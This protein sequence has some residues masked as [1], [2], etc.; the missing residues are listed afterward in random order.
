M[1][2]SSQRAFVI[3]SLLMAFVMGASVILPL[4]R[5]TA[6]H[7]PQTAEEPTP[8]P[9]ATPIPIPEDPTTIQF[10]STLLHPSGLFTIQQPEGWQPSNLSNN[11]AEVKLSMTNTELQTVI[12]AFV[13]ILP[14][15]P[16]DVEA[17]SDFLNPGRL[18]VTWRNYTTW[19]E[20]TRR[21]EGDRVIIDFVA[22]LGP[23][24]FIARQIS[25][26][27][28]GWV[29]NVRVVAPESG[30]ALLRYL[31]DQTV[32]SFQ[33][34]DVYI[35]TPASWNAYYDAEADH[36]L[37][38]PETWQLE[39]SAPGLPATI[40]APD[41][42]QLR[43]ELIE[44]SVTSEDDARAF[45]ESLQSNSEVLSVTT[46]EVDGQMAYTV[47]YRT[48]NLDG[49]EQSG[50]VMLIPDGENTHVAN[51]T[52][53]LPGIDLADETAREQ[54]ADLWQILSTFRPYHSDVSL[55]AIS[56]S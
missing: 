36:I 28:N 21:I 51:L 16:A 32:A 44:G 31:I 49:E 6:T 54:H 8:A 45:V 55:A 39:D 33:P 20:S 53:S 43:V 47:S 23:R 24:Q 15:A 46:S 48:S 34:N 25:W 10:T 14:E 29:Y 41:G 2:R 37:R 11:G 19:E 13:D 40:T 30:T 22:T 42:T 7:N 9:T 26:V 56:A 1:T 17:L 12:E 35:N 52:T 50:L 3:F 38:Y 27:E 4:L 5:N 18:N